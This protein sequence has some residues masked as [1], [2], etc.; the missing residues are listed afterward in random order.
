MLV[1]WVAS[2]V[3]LVVNGCISICC[4][5]VWVQVQYMEW[6]YL[7]TDTLDTRY[8]PVRYVSFY[9]VEVYHAYEILCIVLFFGTDGNESLFVLFTLL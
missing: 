8:I 4:F 9:R 1:F 7:R 3:L 6:S 5:R 2:L